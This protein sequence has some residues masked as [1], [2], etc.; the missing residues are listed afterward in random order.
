MLEALS[1]CRNEL[2]ERFGEVGYSTVDNA[3]AIIEKA[4]GKTWAEIKELLG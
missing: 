4:T 3:T 1:E 2:A